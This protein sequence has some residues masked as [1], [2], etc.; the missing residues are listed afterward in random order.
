MNLLSQENQYQYINIKMTS[1]PNN[2]NRVFSGTISCDGT[3][4]IQVTKLS[5]ESTVNQLAQLIEQTQ[6]S[7]PKIRKFADKLAFYFGPTIFAMSILVFLI[8]LILIKANKVPKEWY[9]EVGE[10]LFCILFSLSVLVISCPCALG[11]AIPTAI[12][13]A[14]NVGIKF[15]VLYKSSDVFEVSN[16]IDTIIFD[17]TGTLTE[18]KPK[19]VKLQLLSERNEMDVLTLIGSA[20][21]GSNHPLAEGIVNIFVKL[22]PIL[23]R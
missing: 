8:W 4:Y 13:V 2:K 7:T 20:E 15:G 14:T 21:K 9:S 3:I 6:L 1:N 5:S 19:V 10:I 12:M 16:E 23:H 22:D 11:L 18:G 17:K